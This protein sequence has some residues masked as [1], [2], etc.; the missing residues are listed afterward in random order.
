MSQM[1]AVWAAN[2]GAS[3]EAILA[4]YYPGTDIDPKTVLIPVEPPKPVEPIYKAK[5]VTKNPLSLNI[6]TTMSKSRSLKKVPRGDEVNVLEETTATWAK[7]EHGGVTGYVDRRYLEKIGAEQPKP[8]PKPEPK[9]DPVPEQKPE[10]KPSDV[11]YRAVVR[12]RFPLSLNLWRDASKARSLRKIPNGATVDVLAE[13]THVWTKVRYEG[14]V[15]YVDEQYLEKEKKLPDKP[16]YTAT[17]KTMYPLSLNIWRDP[18]KGISLAKVPRG[19]EVHVM[20]ELDKTWAR[21]IYGKTMG[22]VDRQYLV[23][24]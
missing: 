14:T 11:L 2:N 1:G 23:K 15:G 4:Y 22:F 8:E 12:T 3:H 10:E 5:V 17:V 24:K 16:L 19:A 7:I 20:Q 18:R 6:W 13:V 21:I 9:P